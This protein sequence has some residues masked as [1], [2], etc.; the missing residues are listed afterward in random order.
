MYRQK[1]LDRPSKNF[2]L[3]NWPTRG[4][5]AD[6][7]MELTEAESMHFIFEIDEECVLVWADPSSGATT[8]TIEITSYPAI[9]GYTSP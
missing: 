2:E 1:F 3:H 9:Q 4:V 5:G 7:M 8:W 6:A